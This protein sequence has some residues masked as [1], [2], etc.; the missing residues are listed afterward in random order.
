LALLEVAIEVTSANWLLMRMEPRRRALL[1]HV[2]TPMI[3]K[4]IP[5]SFMQEETPTATHPL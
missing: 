5:W 3:W 2:S 4:V 1:H